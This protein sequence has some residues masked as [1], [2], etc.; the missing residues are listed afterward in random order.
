L[1]YVNSSR[2]RDAASAAYPTE[3]CRKSADLR[4]TPGSLAA[5]AEFPRACG[6]NVRDFG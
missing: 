1:T 5:L 2:E 4:M 3:Q 6:I